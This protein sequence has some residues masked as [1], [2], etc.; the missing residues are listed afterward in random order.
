MRHFAKETEAKGRKKALL[1]TDL[2]DRRKQAHRHQIRAYIL[3]CESVRAGDW[4]DAE[5]YWNEYEIHRNHI[6][7]L[8]EI[9]KQ[10]RE[11]L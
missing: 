2:Y 8:Q 3:K 9:E 11:A 6:E 10:I 1:L 7:V 5:R 4:G